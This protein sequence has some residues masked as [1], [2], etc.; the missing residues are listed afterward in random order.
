MN[1]THEEY[2][3]GQLQT[4]WAYE[5][6]FNLKQT[7]PVKRTKF[8]VKV[9][10]NLGVSYYSWYDGRYKNMDP[11]YWE[12]WH[13]K[14]PKGV[15]MHV[16]H[17][18]YKMMED[19]IYNAYEERLRGYLVMRDPKDYAAYIKKYNAWVWAKFDPW[20]AVTHSRHPEWA[21]LCE[22]DHL[23]NVYSDE[24]RPESVTDRHQLAI[25]VHSYLSLLFPFDS[26]LKIF[27]N[28][29]EHG[30]LRQYSFFSAPYAKRDI[31]EIYK[32]LHEFEFIYITRRFLANRFFL[33]HKPYTY[34]F[35]QDNLQAYDYAKKFTLF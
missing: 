27:G 22:M 9:N 14:T 19:S 12:Q 32:S 15:K 33:K 5:Q 18:E 26:Y 13:N 7:R 4:I 24:W 17:E 35:I 10:E 34:S 3:L 2:H 30:I 31:N 6:Y 28:D 21:F 23:K 29:M 20:W 25:D 1:K 8:G 11:W 16:L